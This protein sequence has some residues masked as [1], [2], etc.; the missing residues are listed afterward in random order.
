[1]S[2]PMNQF[3]QILLNH[4]SFQSFKVILGTKGFLGEGG[5][6]SVIRSQ[7][8]DGA[9]K[10]IVALKCMPLPGTPDSS[11]KSKDE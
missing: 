8:L 1:M 11:R 7:Y 6:G 3:C 9:A 10:K 4:I 2:L 5:Y